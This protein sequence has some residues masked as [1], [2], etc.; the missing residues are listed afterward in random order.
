MK[1][2]TPN[3][4]L[5]N[6]INNEPNQS[7]KKAKLRKKKFT[8]KDGSFFEVEKI[9]GKKVIDGVIKYNVKW[10]DWPPSTNTWETVE[11]LK[12]VIHLVK[13]YELEIGNEIPDYL[14]EIESNKSI[15]TA[16][17]PVGS[18]DY[19]DIPV[20]IIKMKNSPSGVF[21]VVE[22]AMRIDSGVKPW[23]SLV[24]R[25]T[26]RKKKPLLLIDYYERRMKYVE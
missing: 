9:C 8:Y 12:N 4:Q 20:N 16:E 21:G 22:W 2:S 6:N 17:D 18:L 24:D 25:N 1:K 10:Q 5:K 15:I 23:N 19:D 14:Q 7:K 13:A 3:K 11:Y 26:L